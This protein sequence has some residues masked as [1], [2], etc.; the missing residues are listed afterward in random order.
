MQEMF[1]GK[2]AKRTDSTR[3]QQECFINKQTIAKDDCRD[4]YSKYFPD[5]KDGNI[6]L[7]YTAC[8]TTADYGNPV[9]PKL[10]LTIPIIPEL[11]AAK[12]RAGLLGTSKPLRDKCVTEYNDRSDA[13]QARYTECT[14][15]AA[16]VIGA[17]CPEE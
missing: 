10:E 7:A 16:P 2:K 14:K 6:G 17:K 5:D 13:I 9:D 15:E 1:I 11:V 4:I 3:Q 8:W 12:V